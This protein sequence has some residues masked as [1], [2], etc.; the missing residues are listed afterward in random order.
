MSPVAIPSGVIWVIDVSYGTVLQEQRKALHE[1]T[2]QAIEG[3][4]TENLDDH[5]SELAH[6]YSRSENTE[7]AVEYQG[8]AGQQAFQRSAYG[9]TLR[10]LTMAIEVLQKLPDTCERSQHELPLQIT[11]GTA[12]SATK[13]FA[14]PEVERAYTRAR[15]LCEQV[16]QPTQLAPALY[17]LWQMYI[18]RAEYQT[19]HELGQQLFMLAQRA[20]DLALLPAA[21]RALGEPLLR[22]GEFPAAREHLELGISL[23]DPEQQHGQAFLYGLDP[24]V[25]LRSMAAQALWFLGY[26]EQALKRVQEALTSAQEFPHPHSL[27]LALVFAAWIHQYRREGQ[28]AQEQAE[29]GIALSTEQRFPLHLAVGTHLRGWSS[30]DR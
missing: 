27:V 14:N 25:A 7:K 21:H 8:F 19:A 17:G 20:P 10:H 18:L 12:L 15:E 23:Y 30:K 22:Q 26:P 13:G 1:R 2:A 11:L 3:L 4:Y 28:A 16:G 6:H 9:E 24:G 29:A 5:Y